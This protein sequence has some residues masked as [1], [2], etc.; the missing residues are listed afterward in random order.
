MKDMI[1]D[2]A[3]TLEEAVNFIW[4]EAEILDRQDY[5]AWLPLWAEDAGFYVIPINP[6]SDDFANELNLAYDNEGMRK[7]RAQRLQ[8]GFSISAAPPAK[9]VRT[10]SRFKIVGAEGDRVTIT[11]AQHVVEDKF[12]RQRMFAAN[13]KYTLVK[14][15]DGIRIHEKIVRLLNSDGVLTS[16]SYLF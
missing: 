10:V 13:L 11:A 12:G 16:I 14:T 1:T 2:A 3:I 8:G 6:D 9:T 7:A 5:D 4:D 15:E